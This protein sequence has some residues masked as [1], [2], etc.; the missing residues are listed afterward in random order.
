MCVAASNREKLLNH[1][2]F[3]VKVIRGKL[4]SNACYDKQQVGVY[5]QPFLR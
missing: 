5:L 3:G 2:Y 1:S 4:A